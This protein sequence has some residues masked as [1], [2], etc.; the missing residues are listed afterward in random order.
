VRA[1]LRDPLLRNGYALFGNVG[2]TSVLGFLYWILAARAYSPEYLGL[3]SAALAM[4]QL[5]AGIAGQPSVASLLSRFVPRA[6]SGSTRLVVTAYCLS[7]AAGAAVTLL[8]LAA[9]RSE[10]HA[11][12]VLGGGATAAVVLGV[13]VTVWCVFSLQDAVLTGIR[14]AAW[15][16]LE[17]GLYGVAKIV[18]L[19]VLAP[20]SQRYGIFASWIVPAAVA[21]LPINLLI[22]GRLLPRHRTG[23]V[24]DPEFHDRATLA[25][26]IGGDYLGS[27][28]AL[29]IT[30]LLPILIVARLGAEANGYVYVPFM[31]IDTVDLVTIYLGIALTVEGAADQSRLRQ[32]VASVIRRTSLVVVPVVLILV[33]FAPLV[34]SLYGPLYV[35]HS[36]ALMRILAPAVLARVITN[37]YISIAR[38]HRRVSRIAMAKGALLVLVLGQSWWLMDQIGLLGVAVAFLIS[39]VAVAAALLP[40]MLRMLTR[41]PAAGAPVS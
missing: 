12:A 17:N 16:P 3:G 41:E 33:L 5:L 32:L 40:S 14:Q 26:Y 20:V 35:A 22:F 21:V 23:T 7:G 29:A 28:F 9:T 13:S 37:L 38:V 34:L 1:D 11:P 8:Y 27:I 24:A 39:E 4:A 6:G 19:L 31:I 2:V 25:R 10:L 30:N 15:I 36:S 18:L